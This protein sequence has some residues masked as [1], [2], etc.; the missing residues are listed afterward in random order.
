[1]LPIHSF[2]EWDVENLKFEDLVDENEKSL[3]ADGFSPSANRLFMILENASSSSDTLLQLN[4][5]QSS[6]SGGQIP[7]KTIHFFKVAPL[8]QGR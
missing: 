3:R 6:R 2:G 1:L 8:A 7:M 5:S 4:D